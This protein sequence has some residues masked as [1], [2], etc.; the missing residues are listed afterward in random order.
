MSDRFLDLK[1]SRPR[2]AAWLRAF[3]LRGFGW[4]VL[5]LLAVLAA[6]FV[7]YNTRHSL[8]VDANDDLRQ[9][10]F[11]FHGLEHTNDDDFL[12][13]NGNSRICL[14]QVGRMPNA[15]LSL[16][17]LGEGAYA[18]GNTSLTVGIAD[19]SLATL[20]VPGATRRYH[21][22]LGSSLSQA[23]DV[24]V[25]LKSKTVASPADVRPLGVPFSSLSIAAL[26]ANQPVRPAGLLLGLNLA[27]ALL[28]WWALRR[29]GLADWL[30]ALLVTAVAL[31]VLLSLFRGWIAPGLGLARQM[32]PLVAGLGLL[33]AAAETTSRLRQPAWMQRLAVR[34]LIVMACWGMA[35]YGL[36]WL[37]QILLGFNG[38]WPLKAGLL[39]NLTPF[40]ALPIVVFAVWLWMVLRVLSNQAAD[41]AGPAPAPLP[42]NARWREE[43]VTLRQRPLGAMP[44]RF[45]DQSGIQKRAWADQAPMLFVL[46]GAFLLPVIV[47][48][49]ARGWDSLFS[50][51]RDS[52]FEYYAD[53]FRVGA[54]PV[55][56]MRNFVA[57]SPDLALH[58]S[59]HPPGSILL[60]WAVGQVLPGPVAASWTAI[61]LSTLGALA[62]FWLGA[63][64]GGRPVGLLTGALVAVM[65]GYLVYGATSMDGVFNGLIALAAV[66]F[67]LALEPE[68]R[69]GS[70]IGAGLLI[71][72][73]LFFTYA[74]T[75]LF[76]FG[77]A[78]GLMALIRSW[79][80]EE[81]PGGWP[82]IIIQGLV[83]I[84]TVALVYLAIYLLT[85]FNVIAGSI[86][87]TANNA[88]SMRG[89][90]AAAHAGRSFVPPSIAYYVLYLS[91]NLLPFAFY[92][93]P[94]GLTAITR[95]GR[96]VL[97]EPP[98]DLA[99]SL[100]VGLC[101]WLGGM[102][103]SGLFNR[104]VER[105]WGFTYPLLAALAVVHIWQGEP[106]TRLWR[107]GFYLTLF[108]AHALFIRVVLNTYW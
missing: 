53:V 17:I 82:A 93:G 86:Q 108:F 23:D 24:C 101:A 69:L 36:T 55:G 65:P 105:I 84:A 67:L 47:K 104:E 49:S 92:L 90:D 80:D 97:R 33:W 96:D 64:L 100:T 63:R 51:F 12:W 26:A 14:D 41:L 21:L 34:D 95:G 54:D 59:T 38:L 103:L 30:A 8:R 76:F 28:S 31:L 73:S 44:P 52:T 91:A 79:I 4:P 68:A 46:L 72:L 15:Q 10:F 106:R 57:L 75:Q 107:A 56:F 37:L 27:L 20:P 71:A 32:L 19:Q 98:P 83:V 85:G 58:S 87:A 40:V 13:T 11:N 66:A 45:A 74:T 29:L 70:A 25:S 88:V 2:P 77:I 48:A 81:E 7:G 9:V 42:A 18:L 43:A 1:M 16:R 22:L 60:L 61:A 3:S 102:W 62:A 89:L 5:L 39:P 6:T 35:V 99:T 94:W 50:T 78:V